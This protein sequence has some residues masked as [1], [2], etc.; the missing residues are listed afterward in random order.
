MNSELR[1]QMRKGLASP[2]CLT[3]ELT[4]GC[5]LKCVHCLSSSGKRRADELTTKECKSLIDRFRDMSIFYV[6]IGGGEPMIRRDF[7]EIIEYATQ[8]RVGVKFSTNGSRIDKEAATRLAAMDYLDVQISIDGHDRET[9]DAIR[10]AGSFD[11]A[12]EALS[13]LRDANFK[14]P[15]ISVVATRQ[16]VEHLDDLD[17]IAKEYGAQLRITRLRPSGR[18]VD[19][20]GY[21]NPTSSQ[22]RTLYEWL[23]RRS[24]VLT[25]DSFFHLSPLGEPLDGLNICGAGRVVCLVDPV[26]E[27]YACPFTIDENFKAGNIREMDFEEIWGTSDLFRS[28]RESEG[29]TSCTSCS[30][31][32][33]CN[34]GCMATKYFTGLSLDDPDPDCAKGHGANSIASSATPTLVQISRKMARQVV[35]SSR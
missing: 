25:G 27:V 13:N 4:Y 3:W 24:D 33:A 30:A 14:T 22:Q 9:N 10:G 1:D 16:S 11:M 34:G 31:F 5:N 8:N 19:S 21:L 17:S 2:I 35:T 15:K 20:Y 23:S 26:G 6:N 29:P 18:G 32:A 7:F 12:I 28:F